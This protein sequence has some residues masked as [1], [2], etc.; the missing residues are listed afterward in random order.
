LSQTTA[1]INE[2]G[3]LDN[4]PAGRW[5]PRTRAQAKQSWGRLLKWHEENRLLDCSVAPIK[6]IVRERVKQFVVQEMQRIKLHSVANVLFHLIGIAK[7]AAPNEDWNWLLE[8]RHDLKKRCRRERRAS[9]RIVPPNELYKLG[10]TLM[11]DATRD[12]SNGCIDAEIYVHG[13]LIAMLAC[14]LQRLAAFSALELGSHIER[15]PSL[16]RVKFNAE[17]TKTNQMETGTLPG[18]LT[19]F[20]DLYVDCLRPR[21]LHGRDQSRR[22]WIGGHGRPLS[23]NKIREIIKYRTKQAFGFEICPHSFRHA[24]LTTFTLNQPQFAAYGADL[25]GDSDRIANEHYLIPHRELALKFVHNLLDGR[26]DRKTEFR[27]I[28][29]SAAVS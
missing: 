23:A 10:L 8:I 19:P 25:L 17:M 22:F 16:W 1:E 26:S 11:Q 12:R 4:R 24:A 29:R 27:P 18:S 21:L 3:W 15:G 13:L 5:R 2:P 28:L 9:R 6:L 20:I 14:E 7:S